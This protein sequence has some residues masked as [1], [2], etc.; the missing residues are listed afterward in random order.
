[1]SS[2]TTRATAIA[3]MLS[4]L[5]GDAPA[6]DETDDRIRV[7]ATVPTSLSEAARLNLLAFLFRMAD[8]FGHQVDKD[9]TS[10]IWAEV[11]REEIPAHPA[12]KS[13]DAESEAQA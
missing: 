2:P 12:P 4:A 9:G 6:E 8:R 3:S 10:R 11:D 13:P 5:F 1:M 7:E